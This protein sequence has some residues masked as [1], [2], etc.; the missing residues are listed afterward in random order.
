MARRLTGSF[1]FFYFSFLSF[2][3]GIACFKK[4]SQTDTSWLHQY[5]E[6]KVQ[7]HSFSALAGYLLGLHKK[8]SI[9]HRYS[10]GKL[11]EKDCCS[12]APHKLIEEL[13]SFLSFK[14]QTE[15]CGVD[16]NA[17]QLLNYVEQISDKGAW[18]GIPWH[19]DGT[20]H[21]GRVDGNSQIGG[22]GVA[23]VTLKGEGEFLMGC[24]SVDSGG[25]DIT[26]EVAR[27]KLKAGHIFFMSALSDRLL[28]HKT[29]VSVHGRLA[30]ILRCLNQP[31]IFKND[32]SGQ[33][34]LD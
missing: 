16:F 32:K 2:D 1:L 22:S 3:F 15:L 24:D 6:P 12:F 33:I 4:F 25:K 7:R 26:I 9:R 34:V 31:R 10:W 18:T 13:A 14:F 30:L 5:P 21:R 17:G 8:L 28:K 19:R 29:L 27:I 23:S 20:P 11:N